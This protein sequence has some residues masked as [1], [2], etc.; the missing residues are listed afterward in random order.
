MKNLLD[1][2]IK[3]K[4]TFLISGISVFA[5]IIGLYLI[6]EF[7]K[8]NIIND[9]KN[10]TELSTKLIGQYAISAI[11]FED[12]EG[13]KDILKK[14]D[15]NDQLIA[16]VIYDNSGLIFSNYIKENTDKNILDKFKLNLNKDTVLYVDFFI[17]SSNKIIYNQQ[18]YGNI[19]LIS[20]TKKLEIWTARLFYRT[21]L[22]LVI[23]LLV[24]IILSYFM[25]KL[26]TNSLYEL[27]SAAEIITR[28][29][30]Y[31]IRVKENRKDEVGRLKSIFNQMLSTIETSIK[32]RDAIEHNLKE[33]EQRYKSLVDMSPIPIFVFNQMIL[34]YVNQSATNYLNYTN[35]DILIGKNYKEIFVSNSESILVEIFKPS[36]EITSKNIRDIRIRKM[37]NVESDVEITSVPIMINDI[38]YVLV[39]CIDVSE[40]KKYEK[41]LIE[42][43]EVLEDEVKKQTFELNIALREL[44]LKNEHMQKAEMEIISAKDEAIKANRIKSEFIANISH[45]IRT[46]MNIIIGYSELLERKLEDKEN[47]KMVISIV[48]S[49][50]TLLAIINDILDISK[51][52]AGKLELFPERLD[53]K[54]VLFEIKEMFLPQCTKKGIDFNIS[55]GTSTPRFIYLDGVRLRQILFNLI[56]NAIKFTDDGFIKVSLNSS[57]EYENYADIGIRVEDTG[58]GIEKDKLNYIFDAFEQEKWKGIR[59]Q[60]GTGLGLTITK[61]L[62]EMMN[63]S[64][65]VESKIDQGSNFIVQFKEL[66]IFSTIEE[67]VESLNGNFEFKKDIDYK[68]LVVDDIEPNRIIIRENLERININVY[69]AKN[70]DEVF[71]I[72]E[73]NKIDIILMDLKIPDISGIEITKLLKSYVKFNKCPIIAYTAAMNEYSDNI[74]LF[75]DIISKPVKYEDMIAVIRKYFPDEYLTKRSEEAPNDL[76]GINLTN[77]FESLQEL[78]I[79]LDNDLI[80]KIDGLL[81]NFIIDEIGE[82]IEQINKIS[83]QYSYINFSDYAKNISQ[84]Y[85]E[86]N[87]NKLKILIKNTSKLR[88]SISS[89]LMGF[90]K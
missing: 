13:A 58:I 61:R 90:S 15:A 30:N 31:S 52:E 87:L 8:E 60:Q 26:I 59:I 10:D 28:D 34:E 25:Q 18:Q 82:F 12:K 88:D 69:E 75:D 38:K 70:K 24:S 83:K 5:T 20:S 39:M 36:D 50:H 80:P 54:K 51:I 1:I 63:G 27:T 2:S 86:F 84:A 62:I 48:N 7:E 73:N 45:E 11:V 35:N 23:V 65:S 77:D 56:N 89:K 57:N 29:K 16:A 9:L 17:L 42:L 4:L 43:N 41:N 21:A 74:E 22:I 53:I 46:P 67:Y 68:L 72:I 6:N 81:E 19:I 44:K 37:N 85:S 79:I 66:K 47:K 49:C 40:R 3:Y 33:S 78:L 55:I 76:N 64:I 32:K 71:E 14:I